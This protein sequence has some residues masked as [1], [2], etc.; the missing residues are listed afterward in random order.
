MKEVDCLILSD[1]TSTNLIIPLSANFLQN[2]RHQ[3]YKT[4]IK[5][6]PTRIRMGYQVKFSNKQN[7]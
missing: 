4:L 1:K 3:Y 2:Y 6:I 5:P 7:R